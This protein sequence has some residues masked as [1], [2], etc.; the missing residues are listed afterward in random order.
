[1]QEFWVGFWTVLWYASL[2]AFSVLAAFVIIFGGSDL[3]ALLAALRRRHLDR[4]ASTSP[5]SE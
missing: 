1:M 4:Q 5:P 3:I 2:G